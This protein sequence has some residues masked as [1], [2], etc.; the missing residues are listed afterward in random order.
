MYQTSLLFKIKDNGVHEKHRLLEML[1]KS[2]VDNN[3]NNEVE[4][5]LQI[6][7]NDRIDILH[8][9]E[10]VY[11][12]DFEHIADAVAIKLKGIPAEYRNYIEIVD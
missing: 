6:A 3:C 11:K 2:W 1:F 5:T 4:Y 7:S 8:P 10:E 9:W 12:V